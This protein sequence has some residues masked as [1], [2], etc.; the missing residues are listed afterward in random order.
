[1]QISDDEIARITNLVRDAVGYNPARGD[2]ISVVATPFAGMAGQQLPVWRDP[3]MIELGLEGGKYLGLFILFLFVFFGIIRPLLRTIAPPPKREESGSTKD[4]K[5]KKG[6][7]GKKGAAEEEDEEEEVA[8]RKGV[9][10]V[11]GVEGVEGVEGAWSMGGMGG[12][13][14]MGGEGGI[15]VELSAAAMQSNAFEARL[16]RARQRARDDPKSVAELL[17][18]WLSAGEEGGHK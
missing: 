2:T 3:Q 15:D 8:G 11:G 17:S 4:E 13:A 7:K 1:M 10:G 14:G 9:G 16:E 18:Q 5:G 6:K 12:V